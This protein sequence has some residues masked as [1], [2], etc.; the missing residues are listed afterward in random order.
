MLDESSILDANNVEGGYRNLFTRWCDILKC[1]FMRTANRR[2]ERYPVTFR[3]RVF[4]K[5]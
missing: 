2:A 4:R 1:A 3:N 5:L